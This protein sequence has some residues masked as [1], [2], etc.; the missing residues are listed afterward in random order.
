MR[1]IGIQR[2]TFFEKGKRANQAPPVFL[3]NKAPREVPKAKRH[4]RFTKMNASRS[5]RCETKAFPISL[6]SGVAVQ[7]T[8]AQMTGKPTRRAP[9]FL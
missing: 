3:L 2:Y 8:R 1:R 7:K 6:G 9:V 4:A 5:G